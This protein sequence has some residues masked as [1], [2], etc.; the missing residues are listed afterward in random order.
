MTNYL[1]WMI[2]FFAWLIRGAEHV[3]LVAGSQAR[4]VHP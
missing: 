1:K 3:E 2:M 4:L